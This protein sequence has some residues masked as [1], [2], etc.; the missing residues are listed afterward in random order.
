VKDARAGGGGG[1]CACACIY[2]YCGW[3]RA[4]QEA[5]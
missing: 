2:V 3:M 4:M 1:E 5:P